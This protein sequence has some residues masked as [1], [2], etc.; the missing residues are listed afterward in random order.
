MCLGIPMCLTEVA[1]QQ[2]R[3]EIN[4]VSRAIR[5]D[6]VPGVRVGD[7]VV[8]HAGY[9][10]QSLDVEAAQETLALLSQIGE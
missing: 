6:L 8:V 3:A 5:L 7:Y 10:I 1:G 2:G 9:A 4:G